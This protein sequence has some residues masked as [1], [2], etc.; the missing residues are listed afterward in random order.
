MVPSFFIPQVIIGGW[1]VSGTVVGIWVHQ[2]TKQA[3]ILCGAYIH[4]GGRPS[5]TD[6]HS[7]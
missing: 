2:Y 3:K 7:K 1:C 6:E 5:V 4:V